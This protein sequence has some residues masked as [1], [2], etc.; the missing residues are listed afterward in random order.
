MTRRVPTRIPIQESA[1]DYELLWRC[2]PSL[3]VVL[4]PAPGLRVVAVSDAYLRVVRAA[5]EALVGRPFFE[6]LPERAEGRR[7]LGAGSLRDAIERVIATGRPDAL[8]SPVHGPDGRLRYVIH[9]M[10]A[11]ELEVARSARQRDDALRELEGASRELEAFVHAAAR[12]LRG[13]LRAI[14]AFSRAFQQMQGAL[15]GMPAR[16]LLSRI[17]MQLER[18]ESVIDGLVA[19]ARLGRAG[20]SRARVDITEAANRAAARLRSTQ[21]GREVEIVVAEGLTTWA[22]E[23][24]VRSLVDHLLDNAWKATRATH[25]ARIEVGSEQRD[26]RGVFYV[27]DNGAGFDMARSPEVFTPFSRLR[28][29]PDAGGRGLGLAIVRRIVERHGGEIHAESRPGEGATFFF[30]LGGAGD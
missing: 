11:L 1:P 2:A 15:L 18:M 5:R 26:G 10:D 7:M 19:L 16:D 3:L 21:P 14:D 12:E 17:A 6:A 29:E 30:S 25:G 20:V 27:R 22:D 4:D 28:P 24:L 23:S 13:P 8:N 9:R